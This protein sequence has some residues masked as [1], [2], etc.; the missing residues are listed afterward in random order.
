MAGLQTPQHQNT[1]NYPPFK[2]PISSD[3]LIIEEEVKKSVYTS[4]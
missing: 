1:E 3:T 2:K 4:M